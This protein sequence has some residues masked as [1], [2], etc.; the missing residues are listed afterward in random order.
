MRTAS[1]ASNA[2]IMWSSPVPVMTDGNPSVKLTG[3]SET[4]VDRL[5]SPGGGGHV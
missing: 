2:W 1:R 4:E 3:P 5:A